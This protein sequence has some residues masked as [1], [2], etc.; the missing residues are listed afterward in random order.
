MAHAWIR[1]RCAS[2][3]IVITGAIE[4]PHVRPWSTV[5]RA[6]TGR[7]AV[8][9]KCC[10][11]N[12]AHEPR[13][14]ALLAETRPTLLPTV[15]ALHESRPWML[16]ADG[17]AKLR[18]L[19]AGPAFDV[20]TDILV[21]YAEL[22]REVVPRVDELVAIGTPDHRL[23]HLAGAFESL[24]RDPRV[25]DAVVEEPLTLDERARL[26]AILPRVAREAAE[27]AAL[28][29]P[30]SVQ[31]DD[32]H[33]ANVL[34]RDGRRVVFDWGDACVSHPFFTTLI[35][36]RVLVDRGVAPDAPE[37]ER[38]RDVYLEPW[39]A[40]ASRER[41]L[42]AYRFVPRLGVVDRV[43]TWHR[44]AT[45]ADDAALPYVARSED[46]WLREILLAFS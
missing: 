45:F 28:G 40:I 35:V 37:L 7:D 44:V 43:L 11:G 9:L 25:M 20:W 26:F 46:G 16:L 17:G 2:L 22:Q 13:L 23:E 27:L 1:E 14:T 30:P 39:G 6:P 10:G 36:W 31:H 42:A 24:L 15:L 3:G 19:D 34:V 41:M 32:L 38:L 8:Y 29:I 18:D 21:R 33:D 4:Q 5:F 12:Q